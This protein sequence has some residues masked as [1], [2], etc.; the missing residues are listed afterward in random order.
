MVGVVLAE[1]LQGARSR[2][3]FEELLATLGA[4]PYVAEGPRT[5]MNVGDLSYGLR[6]RGLTVGIVDALIATLAI[7]HGHQVYTLDEHFQRIP[8]VKLHVP[9]AAA[10]RAE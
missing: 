8:G 1:L 9:G 10:E 3:E 4:L 7:E 6:R 2:E 5:W